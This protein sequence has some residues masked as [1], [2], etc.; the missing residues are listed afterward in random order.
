MSEEV[1]RRLRESADA[2][3]PDRERMLARIERGMAR[4]HPAA[5]GR[6]RPAAGWVRIAGAVAGVAGVLVVGAFAVGPAL[7]Q[8]DDGPRGTVA[9][10]P[11]PTA[12]PTPTRTA[13]PPALWSE[14]TVDPGSNRY[15]A[16]SDITFKARRQLTALTLELR[17]AQTGGVADTGNWRSL[18]AEDFTVSVGERGGFLVYRWVLKNG[19]TVPA[20]QYVFAGQYNHA[21]GDRD[22]GGDSYSVWGRTADGE[23]VAVSGDFA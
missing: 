18:P 19:R 12:T 8:D 4:P 17:I 15:W 21:D 1:R 3:H 16:Q 5:A 23:Q 22:A 2:H 6:R 7:R 11:M 9:V 10:T 14:G 13:A 20:G